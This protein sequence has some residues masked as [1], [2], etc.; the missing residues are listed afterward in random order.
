MERNRKPRKIKLEKLGG[1]KECSRMCLHNQAV[2]IPEVAKRSKGRVFLC[3]SSH[4]DYGKNIE[5]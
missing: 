4:P 1:C 5:V 2:A 3:N